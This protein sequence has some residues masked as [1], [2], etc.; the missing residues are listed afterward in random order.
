MYDVQAI[1]QKFPTLQQQVNGKPLIYFDN[2]AT[3]HTPLEVLDAVRDYKERFNANPHRG[4]HYLGIQAT[5]LYEQA[6]EKVA[7]FINAPSPQ[8]VIFVKNATEA[9]NLVAYSYGLSQI[10]AGDD[11]VLCISEHHSNL[12]PWQRVAKLKGA[13]LRYLYLTEDYTL[14]WEEVREVITTKTALVGIA[15]M[16]NVLGTIYPIRELVAY[17]HQQ[18]AVVVVDGAQSVPHLKTDV[19]ELEADFFVF[20]GHKVFAPMGIGVLYGRRELL[21]SMPPFLMGGEMV[22]YVQEQETTFNEIPYKFEAGTPNVEGAVGLAASIDF[23]ASVS[24]EAMQEHEDK[25]TRYALERLQEIPHLTIYGPQSGTERGP[26]MA[27]TIDGCHP[28]DV[29]TIVDQDGIAIRAGHHCAQ[30]LMHYLKAPATSRIS[31]SLYNTKDEI[32]VLI[33]SL[34]GVRGWLGYGS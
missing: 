32:D 22:E 29:A 1:R 8:E 7:K 11:I 33:N 31:F 2:A 6:R 28:H 14:D 23:L 21:E 18:G 26:V 9:L 13:T 19:Q 15:Q 10:N 17:A 5:E 3:T 27:F 12:V 34:Q 4:A 20:S 24:W 25:L 30:P 16:S